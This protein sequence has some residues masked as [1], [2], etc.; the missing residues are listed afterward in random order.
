MEEIRSVSP[1]SGP[2]LFHPP[3]PNPSS[4]LPTQVNKNPQQLPRVSHGLASRPLSSR[5]P[6]DERKPTGQH[7]ME[8]QLHDQ[9]RHAHHRPSRPLR[10]HPLARH[11]LPL[12]VPIHHHRKTQQRNPHRP[13]PQTPQHLNRRRYPASTTMQTI[14]TSAPATT[15]AAAPVA[16]SDAPPSKPS[17]ASAPNFSSQVCI[18]CT[19]ALGAS[20]CA[21]SDNACLVKQCQTDTNCQQSSINCNQY[22]S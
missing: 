17:S 18:D 12:L 22:T 21:A 11:R 13:L 8:H 6:T 7:Q 1:P 14:F 3:L 5:Q 10:R 19:N 15:K 4:N 2:L 20:N 16:T 9:R